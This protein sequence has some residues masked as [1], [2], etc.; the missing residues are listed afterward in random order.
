VT[1]ACYSSIS[2]DRAV[3][4]N[5]L[6]SDYRTAAATFYLEPTQ[7]LPY[8]NS[9]DYSLRPLPGGFVFCSLFSR[10]NGERRFIFLGGWRF[11]P[12]LYL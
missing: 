3:V 11:F 4:G 9:L 10:F 12:P 7:P 1:G 5:E 2:L 8:F 6:Q